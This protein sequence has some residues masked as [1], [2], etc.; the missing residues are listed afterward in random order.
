[1]IEEACYPEPKTIGGS[2]LQTA[3]LTVNENIDK[4]IAQLKAEI[5]RLEQS[6][7]TL[8]PLL[9]MKI[10]DIREAMNY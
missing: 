6:K 8:A 2:M 10:R 1:M 4:K 5:E 7:V 3:N 9:G